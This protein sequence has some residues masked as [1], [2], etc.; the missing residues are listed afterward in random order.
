MRRRRFV[1]CAM[2]LGM[3]MLSSGQVWA[4][5]VPTP[6]EARDEASESL[7]G[8][9]RVD[10][11]RRSVVLTLSSRVATQQGLD[12]DARPAARARGGTLIAVNRSGLTADVWLSFDDGISDFYFAGT[13]PSGYRF[14]VRNLPRQVP[15]LVAAE[16]TN[17]YDGFW[18]WGPRS[19]V[20][21]RKKVKWTLLR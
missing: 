5:G 15:L 18:D 3:L 21:I 10:H 16:S 6:L 9:L 12:G 7:P 13:L 4:D 2:A 8:V 19:F 11:D 20:I 17:F 14:K 1:S